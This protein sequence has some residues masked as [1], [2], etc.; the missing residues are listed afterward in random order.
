VPDQ[1]AGLR[2]E[3]TEPA[4]RDFDEIIDWT[5]RRFGDD[6]AMRYSDLI[7]QA[8]QDLEDDPLRMGSRAIPGPPD[9]LLSYHLGYRRKR[10]RS[11][12]GYVRKPRHMI[13]YRVDRQIVYVLRW[14]TT[15]GS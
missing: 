9:G 10:A 4:A 15:C 7:A 8:F 2:V 13:V 12:L 11:S 3:I 14:S 1:P 5:V 6:A